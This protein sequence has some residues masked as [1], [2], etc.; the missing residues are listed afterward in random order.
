MAGPSGPIR[1]HHVHRTI[2]HQFHLFHQERHLQPQRKEISKLR[3]PFV[4]GGGIMGALLCGWYLYSNAGRQAPVP[5][6]IW[7]RFVNIA[8]IMFVSIYAANLLR[9][10]VEFFQKRR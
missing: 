9:R 1:A 2:V 10:V 5:D 4:I 7:A 6:P 8:L 3:R